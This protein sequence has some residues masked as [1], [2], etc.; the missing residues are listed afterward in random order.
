MHPLF[1]RRFIVVSLSRSPRGAGHAV[2]VYQGYM[3]IDQ[4]SM[5]ILSR[6]MRT[7]SNTMRIRIS[8]S[9]TQLALPQRALGS[10]LTL[11]SVTEL[12]TLA[13]QYEVIC[14]SQPAPSGAAL[15]PHSERLSKGVLQT[16]CQEIIHDH[17]RTCDTAAPQ[18]FGFAVA[19]GG[20]PSYSAVSPSL[21]F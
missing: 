11:E 18:P 9:A 17:I 5:R 20:K 3:R 14:P 13:Q 10:K 4:D 1:G 12:V 16:V 2:V 19:Y 8:L 15:L 6:N 7:D 21:V